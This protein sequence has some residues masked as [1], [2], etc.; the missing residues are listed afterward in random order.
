M[1]GFTDFFATSIPYLQA[2]TSSLSKRHTSDIIL[3]RVLSTR[4]RA[5]CSE[6]H[7]NILPSGRFGTISHSTDWFYPIFTCAEGVKC[8]G[9]ASLEPDRSPILIFSGQPMISMNSK[10]NRITRSSIVKSGCLTKPV[11][12]CLHPISKTHSLCLSDSCIQKQTKRVEMTRL[13][14]VLSAVRAKMARWTLYKNHGNLKNPGITHCIPSASALEQQSST[15]GW[16]LR[17]SPS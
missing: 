1:F 2:L 16:M 10:K 6:P 12:N 7:V 3:A 5:R 15:P 17:A 8:D 14:P 9:I 11:M 4:S 13:C